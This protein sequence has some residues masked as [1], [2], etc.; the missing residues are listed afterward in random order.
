MR[1]ALK[2]LH[3]SWFFL[4]HQKKPQ[5]PRKVNDGHL[6]EFG[7]PGQIWRSRSTSATLPTPSSLCWPQRFLEKVLICATQWSTVPGPPLSAEPT[8]TMLRIRESTQ[9]R[10][11]KPGFQPAEIPQQISRLERW[12]YVYTAVHR[13]SNKVTPMAM[14]MIFSFFYVLL[15]GYLHWP[16][17]PSNTQA[18]HPVVAVDL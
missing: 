1:V 9:Q 8:F 4:G 3:K 2:Q 7:R 14:I 12:V 5:G 10:T 18:D 17:L 6:K 13:L 15:K 11:K 16:L